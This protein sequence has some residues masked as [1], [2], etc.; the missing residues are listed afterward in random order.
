[1]FDSGQD[2]HIIEVKLAPSYAIPT[3]NDVDKD[4]LIKILKGD[5]TIEGFSQK[6]AEHL[7]DLMAT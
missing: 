4:I 5:V 6:R 7:L 3:N 1:M 2:Q